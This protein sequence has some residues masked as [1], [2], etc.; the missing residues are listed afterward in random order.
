[1]REAAQKRMSD[2]KY[3]HIHGHPGN[4]PAPGTQAPDF[5]LTPLKFYELQTQTEDITVENADQLY[6]KVTL[7][8]FRNKV[9]VALIFGSY[10]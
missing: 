5:S 7:S 2:P 10:T 4:G 8:Q 1:M 3:D 6:A 9:P